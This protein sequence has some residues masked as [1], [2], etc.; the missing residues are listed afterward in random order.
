MWHSH[1][2]TLKYMC[3]PVFLFPLFPMKA[4]PEIRHYLQKRAFYHVMTSMHHNKIA[5]RLNVDYMFILAG[6]IEVGDKGWAEP[7]KQLS[8][9]CQS[10]GAPGHMNGT[11]NPV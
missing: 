7:I 2:N 3:I 4:M 9:S 8:K 11:Q 1:T 6:N 5:F 10:P